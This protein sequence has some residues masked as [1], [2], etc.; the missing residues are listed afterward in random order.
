MWHALCHNGSVKRSR[1]IRT[2]T[3]LAL[4][5][6]MIATFASPAGAVWQCEGANCGITPWACCCESPNESHGESCTVST[7]PAG[8]ADESPP[9]CGCVLTVRS[10]DV[11]VSATAPRLS[12]AVF[13]PVLI[14]QAPVTTDLLLL[15]V[16]TRSIELRGPPCAGAALA[17]PSL[18]APP[19]A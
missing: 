9:D 15:E 7:H 10:I 13:H 17:S 8:D 4:L 1:T 11:T 19:V 12:L 2:I 3:L 5:L 16:A 18:R 6:P 14:V